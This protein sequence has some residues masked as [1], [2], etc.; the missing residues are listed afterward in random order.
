MILTVYAMQTFALK[1]AETTGKIG[2]RPGVLREKNEPE[3]SYI[4]RKGLIL[5]LFI[6]INSKK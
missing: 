4:E 1:N 3:I 2:H 5:R 6:K